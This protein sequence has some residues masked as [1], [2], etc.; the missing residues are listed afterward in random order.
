MTTQLAT[1]PPTPKLSRR[2]ALVTTP[3]IAGVAF[4]AAWLA[5]LAV[6]PTN[7]SVTASSATVVS[8]Y[9]GHQGVAVTQYV[10]VEGLAGLA[11]VALVLALGKA[12][13]RHVAGGLG[14]VAVLAGIGAAIVSLLECALGL[15][16][17]GAVVPDRQTNR[18]GV[19]FDLIN[20]LD[21]VKMLAFAVMALAAVG[22]ARRGGPLPRWLGYTAAA[23]AAAM[24]ASGIGY[25]LGSNTVAQT[26]AVS[27]P[28]LLVWVFGTGLVLGRERA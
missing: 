2:R 15:W 1:A 19:L 7:P 5:G 4:V 26:A 28:L 9:T 21:G 11:V 23:L 27:L 12:T 6:W 10:L 17:A 8:D 16:L 18:A 20:R 24:T 25:L 14:R 22:M 13:R 3:A